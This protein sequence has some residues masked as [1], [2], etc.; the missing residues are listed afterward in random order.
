MRLLYALAHPTLR[1]I[2]INMLMDGGFEVIPSFCHIN[3]RGKYRLDPRESDNPMTEINRRWRAEC[4]IPEEDLFK[5]RLTDF[6]KVS[7]TPFTMPEGRSRVEISTFD[8]AGS[9][10]PE[11]AIL[12][13]KYIDVIV[14]QSFPNVVPG[15]LKWFKGVV[16]FR[17]FGNE[18]PDFSVWTWYKNYL[19][20]KDSIAFEIHRDRYISLSVF[21]GIIETEQK[22]ILGKQPLVLIAA[23]M[24]GIRD[25]VGGLRWEGK[26]SL[27]AVVT[28]I[29]Y[30]DI[31]PSWRS[32]YE[33]FA[34]AFSNLDFAVFGKNDPNNAYCKND[35]HIKPQIS[36]FQ[37]YLSMYCKY[38]VFCNVGKLKQH[39]Q[40]TPFEAAAM[41][42]PVLFLSSSAIAHEAKKFFSDKE[43]IVMGMCESLQDMALRAKACLDDVEYAISLRDEQI[44][45][46]HVTFGADTARKQAVEFR[47]MCASLLESSQVTSSVLPQLNSVSAGRNKRMLWAFYHKSNRFEEVPLWIKAGYEI[48][49]I[50]MP[51]HLANYQG[52]SYD[53]ENDPMYV[54]W[55]STCTLDPKIVEVLRDIP[56]VKPGSHLDQGNI[57][58]EQIQWL[59][60]HFGYIYVPASVSMAL[61]LLEGGYKGIIL[62]RY[63]GHYH[64]DKNLTVLSSDVHYQA[65]RLFNNYI[66]LPGMK[67]LTDGESSAIAKPKSMVDVSYLHRT[68]QIFD[69]LKWEADSSAAHVVTVISMLHTELSHYYFNFL[70]YFGHLPYKI[71]GKNDLEVLRSHEI[72]DT[73]VVGVMNKE[74]DVYR[75]FAKARVY[76]EPGFNPRHS[77]YTPIEALHIG[78]PVIFHRDSGFANEL[79]NF[80]VEEVLSKNG[81]C[82]TW[83]SMSILAEKCL[84]DIEFAKK[85]ANQQKV[86]ISFISKDSVVAQMIEVQRLADQIRN[87]YF[88]W[89][90]FPFTMLRVAILFCLRSYY[91]MKRGYNKISRVIK[92]IFKIFKVI[93]KVLRKVFYFLL[94]ILGVIDDKNQ[95]L[96][97]IKS[98]LIQILKKYNVSL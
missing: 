98:K 5:I 18:R 93:Y 45:L 27:P 59:N 61:H 77:H 51:A 58:S 38:R 87:S 16:V 24:E 97:R 21:N 42:V 76:I 91:R 8:Q 65:L 62:N 40:Y 88:I 35:Y 56:L 73:D 6:Y 69:D 90:I 71:L 2:D 11:Q 31:S 81:M 30:I 75:L 54:D 22:S 23:V 84:I 86:F 26:L 94:L 28:N 4:S 32:Y 82:T 70:K 64:L 13:N 43:L 74:E 67:K 20:N 55:K 41:G 1:T 9:V 19:Y 7:D 36:D 29:S 12:I 3:F 63:Y 47:K 49:P 52:T 68:A 95:V 96:Q 33:D 10:T 57:S 83:E 53:D 85:L 60:N 79:S 15:I 46:F 48:V 66:W 72:Y 92:R 34:K 44:K 37:E 17:I 78:I 89:D 80:F 14:V 50:R 25:Q 39:S